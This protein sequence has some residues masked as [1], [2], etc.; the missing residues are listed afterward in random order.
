M[1]KLQTIGVD[2]AKNVIR[3]SVVSI[4]KKRADE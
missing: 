1:K 3:V 2:L 4:A